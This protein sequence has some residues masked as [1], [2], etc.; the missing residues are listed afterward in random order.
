MALSQA[1]LWEGRCQLFWQFCQHI[2]PFL[3]SVLR[4]RPKRPEV[5]KEDKC[6]FTSGLNQGLD[7]REGNW[8][9]H[10]SCVILLLEK[11][12]PGPSMLDKGPHA[13]GTIPIPVPSKLSGTLS[14]QPERTLCLLPS[15]GVSAPCWL[16]SCLGGWG[17]GK[18]ALAFCNRSFYLKATLGKS[19]VLTQATTRRP[20]KSH[21]WEMSHHLVFTWPSDRLTGLSWSSGL[22]CLSKDEASNS[23]LPLESQFFL[24]EM[25]HWPLSTLV[26]YNQLVF[27]IAYTISQFSNVLTAI[28][29]RGWKWS[30]STESLCCCCRYRSLPQGNK[31]L[32]ILYILFTL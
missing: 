21:M 29:S 18:A 15:T 14:S 20:K 3:L 19:T 26:S 32:F 23:S 9:S 31:L 22:W 27:Q 13:A 30:T 4:A 17:G 16:G 1:V 6:L 11:W 10:T 28:I 25:G 8:L 5:C 7:G 12:H 2:S 24:F